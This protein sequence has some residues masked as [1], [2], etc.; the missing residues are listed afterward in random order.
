MVAK[1]LFLNEN[2]SGVCDGAGVGTDEKPPRQGQREIR[3]PLAIP[4]PHSSV[5]GY[6]STGVPPAISEFPTTMIPPKFR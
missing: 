6:E 3:S 4:S 1:M 5:R 2:Q